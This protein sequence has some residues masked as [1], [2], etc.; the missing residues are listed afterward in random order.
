M[1][2]CKQETLISRL[3][4]KSDKKM[5]KTA[6]IFEKKPFFLSFLLNAIEKK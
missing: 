1:L 6:K 3:L 2:T 4:N 5:V